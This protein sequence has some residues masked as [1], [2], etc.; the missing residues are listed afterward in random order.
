MTQN[1]QINRAFLKHVLASV[2]GKRNAVGDALRLAKNELV[3][4]GTDTSQNKLHYV[5]LGD[6]ALVLAAP[7]GQVVIDSIDGKAVGTG[8]IELN[9]GSQAIVSGHIE[10]Q[11][12]FQGII[13]T[14]VF[15][16]EETILCKLNEPDASGDD[17]NYSFKT[18]PNIIYMG[19]DSVKNGQFR[20]NFAVPKDISYSTESGQ[21]I[22]YAV[23]ND[24][25]Q[26]ANGQFTDFVLAGNGEFIDDG[27]GPNIYCYLN[28]SSFQNGGTVNATP[29]FYATLTD[30]DGINAAGSGIGHDLELIIDGEMQRTYNLNSYFQYDFG[31]YR[32]GSVGF[33]IPQLAD[34]PHKLV[35]RAW[36]ILNNPS[37]AELQFVVDSNYEP[38]LINVVCTKNP[39]STFTRFI[40]SHDRIGSQMDLKL[41][42]FDPSGRVIWQRSESGVPTDQTY[43][44]DWDLTTSNGG[45]LRTGVYLYR[46]SIS[47]GGSSEASLAKKL[48]VIGNK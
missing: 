39:A 27:I 21:I 18:R 37:T 14:Q 6:P 3:S 5:L 16:V 9:A 8:Q 2:E 15:D 7:V 28:S 46:V 17:T 10:G 34:G 24:R 35:F 43:T 48:I 40:V 36:D 19:S 33:S 4:S 38:S 44:I 20:I 45:R 23:S 47:S 32:S 30:K 26:M 12:D 41:E 42:V 31:D 1:R 11:S 22:A 29:Y 13:T 25:R